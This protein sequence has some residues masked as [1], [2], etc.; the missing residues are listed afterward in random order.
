MQQT[1]AS[2]L[3]RRLQGPCIAESARGVLVI[4]AILLACWVVQQNGLTIFTKPCSI[5]T[6]K[7]APQQ[8]HPRLLAAPVQ[9]SGSN[10]VVLDSASDSPNVGASTI[11][12]AR[13]IGSCWHN[14]TSS[15]PYLGNDVF[16]DFADHVFVPGADLNLKGPSIIFLHPQDAP[17][18][19]SIV[20][21]LKHKVVLVSNSNTDQC[22]PSAHGDNAVS[23]KQ[24]IDVILNISMVASW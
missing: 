23:W 11:T 5:L 9:F 8:M 16:L 14:T 6:R 12:M 18:F 21:E 4:G 19:A 2:Y 17:A 15:F 7:Q 3:Q 1:G 13:A 22:L 10:A 24:H 20:P